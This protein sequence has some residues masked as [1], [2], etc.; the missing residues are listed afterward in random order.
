MCMAFSVATYNV[1]AAAYASKR[2]YPRTP[3]SLLRATYRRSLLLPYLLGLDADILCLQEVDA[4]TFATL[5]HGLSA[6]GF[7]AAFV[8]KTNG[9][10]DGC[11]ILAC[12]DCAAWMRHTHL[13]YND[14][15]P[16]GPS[17]G[18]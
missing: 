2:L 5:Q 16:D 12:R 7:V 3:T 10:P 17:S 11:A 14:R 1:L 18:H 13:A 9:K 4:E 15:S 8:Q 6:A